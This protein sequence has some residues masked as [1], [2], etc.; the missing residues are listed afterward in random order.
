MAHLE[1]IERYLCSDPDTELN[2]DERRALAEH[3][4]NC[5][6]C[7][8]HLVVERATKAMLQAEIPIVLA[9]DALRRRIIAGLDQEDRAR[10]RRRNL[11][12]RR[13]M[14][15]MAAASIA[16][17]LILLLA[18]LRSR[19]ALDPTFD[20]AIASY[21]RSEQSFTP[22]V[23]VRSNDELAVALINQFGV[24]LVWDFSSMG[25]APV[26]G[27]IDR[28]ADGKAVAYSMYKGGRG[29][30]LCIISRDDTFHFPPGG[31]IVKGIHI[32]RHD[33]FTIAA[34]NR[35]AVFCVMVT[36]LPVA[37]L[38]RVFDHLPA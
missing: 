29:S 8:E 19:Q 3:L 11:I 21:Q 30:L 18:N 37:D 24:P 25:L 6:E 10:H 33:G 5:P 28:N 23:G 9:P 4:A 26:G 32:Y 2:V 20:A 16:A 17:C 15:W 31:Q 35:Y 13:Q 34:T 38:A 27:R 7:R 1:Y 12:S 14:T 36:R 22:T